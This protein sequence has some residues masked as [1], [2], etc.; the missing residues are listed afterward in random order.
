MEGFSFTKLNQFEWVSFQINLLNEIDDLYDYQPFQKYKIH[1]APQLSRKYIFILR[2]N[3]R[4]LSK[5][6]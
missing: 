2:N 4:D 6:E 1:T 5:K 3:K